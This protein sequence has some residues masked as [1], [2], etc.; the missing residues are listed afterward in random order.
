MA[1]KAGLAL[2]ILLIAG[3]SPAS[4][5]NA[6]RITGLQVNRCAKADIAPQ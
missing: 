3:I 5:F 2:L 1:A 6:G 4:E